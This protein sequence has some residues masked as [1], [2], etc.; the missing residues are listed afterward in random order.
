MEVDL[1]IFITLQEPFWWFYHYGRRSE[2][3]I[4]TDF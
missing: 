2:L 1:A 3:L 4:T